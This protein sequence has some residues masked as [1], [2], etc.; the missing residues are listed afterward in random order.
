MRVAGSAGYVQ[1]CCAPL[2]SALRP[3][4]LRFSGSCHPGPETCH[5]SKLYLAI[6]PFYDRMLAMK[7]YTFY[8]TVQLILFIALAAFIIVFVFPDAELFHRA[9]NDPDLQVI[10]WVLWGI[11]A[12][13]YLFILLDF[14]FFFGYRKEYGEMEQALHE[15]P[16]SGIANRLSCDAYIERY[17]DKPLPPNMACVMLDLT[18]LAD[19]NR[20]LGHVRGNALIRDFSELLS[21]SAAGKCFVGRNGGNKF[22]AIFENGSEGSINAFLKALRDKSAAY[23]LKHEDGGIEFTSG[24]AYRENSGAETITDLISLAFKRLGEG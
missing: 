14:V 15:D 2:S 12:L 6:S 3:P 5:L 22:I 10:L 19:V 8:K 21:E 18:S 24:T 1:L 17:L 11:L 4:A 7:K 20:D 23:N 13:S 9:A 16:V